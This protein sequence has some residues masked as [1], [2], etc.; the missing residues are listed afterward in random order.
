MRAWFTPGYGEALSARIA[1]HIARARRRVRI[2]SPVIT[3][4]PVLATLAQLVSEGKLDIAGCVDAPQV[5]GVIHQWGENGNVSWKLPLLEKVLAG[6][7]SGKPS[8]PWEPGAPHDFMHAKVTIADDVVFVGSFNLSRSG[9]RNAENVLEI[10]DAALADRLAAYVD[11]VRARYPRFEFQGARREEARDRPR[12]RP[13]SV[14]PRRDA[15]AR[16]A[17]RGSRGRCGTRRTG[18][19]EAVV[20]GRHADARRRSSSRLCR[21]GRAVAGGRARR[22]RRGVARRPAATSAVTG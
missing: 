6:A 18:T 5:H 17:T 13:G 1:K 11:E 10:H 2:C 21:K 15:S 22:G 8:T 7:F 20:R 4:A 3:A 9:E 19:V 16:R 12:T 14:L